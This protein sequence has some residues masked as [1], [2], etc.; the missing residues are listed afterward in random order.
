ML[1]KQSCCRMSAFLSCFVTPFILLNI[2]ILFAFFLNTQ[3]SSPYSR[4]GLMTVFYIGINL[5]WYR[6]PLKFFHA[7]HTA[8]ILSLAIFCYHHFDPNFTA[9]FSLTPLVSIISISKAVCLLANT[10]V[11]SLSTFRPCLY[12]FSL[13]VK[14]NT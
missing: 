7:T 1:V 12:S 6:T 8:L 2:F 10:S 3:V 4:T 5:L 13:S 9:C 14:I 11:L